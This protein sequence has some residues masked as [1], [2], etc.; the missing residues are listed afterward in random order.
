VFVLNATLS[1]PAKMLIF[2]PP[3]RPL[4]RQNHAV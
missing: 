3:Y 2:F 1:K 4:A